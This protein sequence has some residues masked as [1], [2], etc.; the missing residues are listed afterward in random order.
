MYD[1]DN[2]TGLH[3]I[4]F[5]IYDYDNVTHPSKRAWNRHQL[6]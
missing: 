6:T 4:K 5:K 1:Y 2:V 3:S